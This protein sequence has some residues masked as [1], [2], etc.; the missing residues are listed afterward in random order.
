MIKKFLPIALVLLLASCEKKFNDIGAEVLPPSPIQGNKALYPVN[1]SHALIDVAQTNGGGVLHL[2]EQNNNLFGS[3]SSAV[4]SQFN[5]GTYPPTFGDKNANVEISKNLDEQETIT[6]VWLEIPFFTNQKDADG[7]GLVDAYDVDDTDSNSDSDGD[8]VSDIKERNAGTDPLNKD[9]D[10]DGI[11]DGEDTE[12]KNPNAARKLYAIDSL[13]GNRES[14]FDVSVTKLNYFLRQL[15]PDQNFEQ[16]Q[17]YYSNFNIDAFKDQQ[18]G[19]E[20]VQLNFNEIVIEGENN[21]LTPRLRIPLNKTIFQQLIIDKEGDTALSSVELWHDYFRAISVE[22]SNF[23]SPLLMLLDFNKM[24]IRMAYTYKAEIANSDPVK[25]EDK[26]KEYL[27]NAGAL[28]FNTIKQTVAA[29]SELN[30][31]VSAAAPSKIALGGGLGSTATIQLFEDNE[32]LEAIKGQSWLLNEAN[33]TFY[34]DKQTVAQYGLL[35]PKR[36]YLYNAKTNAAIIDYS[37]DVTSNKSLNKLVYGG[38]MSEDD[39]KQYY[40]IRITDHLRNIISNDSI[41]VPLRLSLADAFATQG[42]IAMA[43][44]DNVT[45][46]KV[47]TGTISAPKAVVFVGPNPTDPSLTALKLQLEVFYT[48]ID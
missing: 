4:V 38:F 31:I 1:V 15:D 41:N 28:K 39:E 2:G 35:L 26:D 29:T 8:G 37:Q 20:T 22:V 42:P 18:L 27:I 12:S 40:K 36:L 25:T 17:P 34:V 3:T 19:D 13:F 14:S 24:V 45:L 5:L 6:D 7:D 10:G 47:P 32:V 9:T 43:K 44:V 33:L 16:L 23:S 21:N 46:K 30:D 48:E 11:P